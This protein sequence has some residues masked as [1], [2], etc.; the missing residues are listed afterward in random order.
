MLASGGDG[1]YIFLFIYNPTD[2]KIIRSTL[3]NQ[4]LKSEAAAN[5][6]TKGA[7]NLRRKWM[8]S[9]LCLHVCRSNLTRSFTLVPLSTLWI[10]WVP[11][12]VNANSLPCV[13]WAL[14]PHDT[15]TH[16][17]VF[18]TT[19]IWCKHSDICKPMCIDAALVISFLDS[20]PSCT[21]EPLKKITMTITTER[22]Q[23]NKQ[24]QLQ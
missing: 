2:L 24:K 5:F 7:W 8:T 21:D 20:I 16:V 13:V 4:W 11:V 14:C 6:V 17:W 18:C 22:R 19:C 12:S 3:S 10:Y 23:Q 1:N 15:Y 9:E